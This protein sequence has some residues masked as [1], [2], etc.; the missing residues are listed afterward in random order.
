M[1]V[2]VITASIL[3]IITFAADGDVAKGVI[4]LWLSPS[5]QELAQAYE[6]SDTVDFETVAAYLT[7]VQGKKNRQRPQAE[8]AVVEIQALPTFD[9]LRKTTIDKQ[10]KYVLK[11]NDSDPVCR[12]FCHFDVDGVELTASSALEWNKFEKAF[13][14]NMV[15][16]KNYVSLEGRCLD[17]NGVPAG[18][19]L[20]NVNLIRTPVEQDESWMRKRYATITDNNG[21]WRIDG[22]ERPSCFQLFR[23]LCNTNIMHRYDSTAPAYGIKIAACQNPVCGSKCA[24]GCVYVSNV[25]K[26]DRE[27]LESLLSTYKRKT[28]KCWVRPAPM[29]DFPVSTN[30]V[31]YVPDIVL[32]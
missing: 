17:A 20:I 10:C 13:C 27:G 14:Q 31:I 18:D 25:T 19:A 23:F 28:G 5:L 6:K 21:K 24:S 22:I 11:I 3:L 30:N 4:G 2:K 29:T 15:L 1:S 32:K 7:E 12:I 16:R 26:S 8:K 9:I